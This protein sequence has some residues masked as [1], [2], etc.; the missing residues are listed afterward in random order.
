MN[1]H[2]SG[3]GRLYDVYG[4]LAPYGPLFIHVHRDTAPRKFDQ[5]IHALYCMGTVQNRRKS[6]QYFC[7]LYILKDL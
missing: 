1:Q 6:S 4:R 7:V 3:P 2:A 5:I